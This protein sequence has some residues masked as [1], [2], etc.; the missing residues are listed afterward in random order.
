MATLVTVKAL[1]EFSS[2]AYGN[3]SCG[4]H[5]HISPA[6]ADAWEWQGLV[7]REIESGEPLKN[8]LKMKV[9][10]RDVNKMTKKEI[11]AYA[12]VHFGIEMDR[13]H[14]VSRMRTEVKGYIKAAE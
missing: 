9:P 1:R 10:V 14:S 8:K 13:R 5:I 3:V 11:E 6:R 7:T 4:Q 2:T 12:R